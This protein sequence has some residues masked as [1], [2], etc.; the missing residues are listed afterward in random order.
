MDDGGKTVKGDDS[1]VAK[2]VFDGS[3]TLHNWP[4]LAPC[5][6]LLAELFMR[7]FATRRQRFLSYI[8]STVTSKPFYGGSKKNIFGKYVDL[9]RSHFQ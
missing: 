5:S 3:V 4:Y 6:L 8:F 2:Y 9:P 7:S 1:P